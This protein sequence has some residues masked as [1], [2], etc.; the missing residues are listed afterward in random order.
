MDL[1]GIGHDITE[2]VSWNLPGGQQQTS[3]STAGVPAKIQTEDLS[4]TSLQ[5]GCYTN[6]LGLV[7]SYLVSKYKG[8]AFCIFSLSVSTCL[9]K[10]YCW[11]L[12]SRFCCTFC[13]KLRN[14]TIRAI[15]SNILMCAGKLSLK[16]R[17]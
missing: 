15:K 13:L 8:Y 16:I 12:I 5:H 11:V 3:V 7:A 6:L 2:I 4:N 1:G 10:K 14:I 17:R 9:K